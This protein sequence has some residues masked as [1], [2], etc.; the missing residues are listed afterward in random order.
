MIFEKEDILPKGDIENIERIVKDYNFPWFYRQSTLNNF[1]Y[2]S[3][4]LLD[5]NLGK[6]SPHYDY[7]KKNF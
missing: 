1:P 5:P 3:H 7:F 6:N 2:N 4:A